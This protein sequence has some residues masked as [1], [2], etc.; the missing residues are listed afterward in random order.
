[1]NLK[2]KDIQKD[3]NHLT[4]V[5]I[6]DIISNYNNIN[7]DKNLQ[8]KDV[9]YSDIIINKITIDLIK[10]A[11][12]DNYIMIKNNQVSLKLPLQYV[13]LNDGPNKLSIYN[14]TKCYYSYS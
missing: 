12:D 1:M 8:V 9:D 6:S 10:K 13:K 14:G 7:Y 3:T 11:I 2:L 4:R 5:Y